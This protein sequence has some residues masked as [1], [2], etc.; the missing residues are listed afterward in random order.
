M[1]M[2]IARDEDGGPE[3]P[4]DILQD[5]WFMNDDGAGVMYH[6]KDTD[7]VGIIKP[8]WTLKDLKDTIKEIDSEFDKPK[9]IVHLRLKTHGKTDKLNTHPFRLSKCSAVAH[10]GVFSNVPK[11]EK[12]S[13]TLKFIHKFLSPLP[14]KVLRH[15][16]LQNLLEEAAR[17]S[18]LAFLFADESGSSIRLINEQLGEWVDGLWY[19]SKPEWRYKTGYRGWAAFESRMG[20]QTQRFVPRSEVHELSGIGIAE[21]FCFNCSVALTLEDQYDLYCA[22]CGVCLVYDISTGDAVEL[23]EEEKTNAV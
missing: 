14:I 18:K 8:L 16:G 1:C 12:H 21:D 5:S 3:I 11:S 23:F 9:M 20:T 17:G 7:S 2:I 19:S 13:D 15:P 10:N 4:A 22:N 6:N